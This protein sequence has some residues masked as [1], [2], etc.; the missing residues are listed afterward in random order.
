MLGPL[1]KQKH[2]D[3]YIYGCPLLLKRRL[4]VPGMEVS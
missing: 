2:V 3:G 1:I 4:E